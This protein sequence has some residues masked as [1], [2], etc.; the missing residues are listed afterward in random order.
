MTNFPERVLLGD[1]DETRRAFLRKV[2]DKEFSVTLVEAATYDDLRGEYD[3]ICNSAELREWDLI[4]LAENLPYG[5]TTP[6]QLLGMYLQKLY[7]PLSRAKLAYVSRSQRPLDLPGIDFSVHHVHIP[8][9]MPTSENYDAIIV[10]FRGLLTRAPSVPEVELPKDDA[11]LREQLR[12]LNEERS[13][14]KAK[15][16]LA[17]LVRAFFD[18]EKVTLK[19]LTQG[20]S[21]ATVFRIVPMKRKETKDGTGENK[22][23][24]G[25]FV[26]KLCPADSEWKIRSEVQ[27]NRK[28][29]D[30]LGVCGY[31]KHVPK[32]VEPRIPYRRE[33][34]DLCQV[35]M[36]GGWYAVCYD[37]LGGDLFGR[38]IDLNR[39]LIASPDNLRRETEGTSFEKKKSEEVRIGVV[40]QILKWLCDQ[41]YKKPKAR[42]ERTLWS[43]GDAPARE[44]VAFPPYQLAGRTKGWILNFLDS[45]A[46]IL[47]E[48]LL[49]GTWERDREAV[50]QLVEAANGGTGIPGLD[51]EM[52]VIL[53]P[54]H[55]DLN[56]NNVL[57]WLNEPGHP[58]LIDF[59]FYQSK[60]HA[61]QDFARLEVEIVFAIMDRQQDNSSKGPAALDYTHSQ[62]TL[63]AELIDH[64][65]SSEIPDKKRGWKSRAYK[66]HVKSCQSL[67]QVVRKKA[68]DVQRQLKG[69]ADSPDFFSEYL[70]ALLYH[71]LRAISYPSLSI[72]KRLLAVYS[73]GRIIEK[74]RSPESLNTNG[75]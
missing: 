37:Y 22:Y 34:Q 56:C 57:L 43:V 42:E 58:F 38:F 74:L 13:I 23:V 2:F 25:E 53:S 45:H 62:L 69:D 61:L 75:V 41:W 26:L 21:G 55:G 52:N 70:P 12:C 63:W 31:T 32:L 33:D 65:L 48:R 10:A 66:K 47:G 50:W 28:A 4:L 51:R 72:F 20:S 19:S 44:Y 7:S 59:P 64:V 54:A 9:D 3:K 15:D 24:L 6:Q 49:P 11:T 30:T 68:S 60:G 67:I 71:T 18:C 1:P 29:G 35:A 14:E 46:G 8:E 5:N 16:Q 73:A 17:R 39:V 36:S 40:E 27:G